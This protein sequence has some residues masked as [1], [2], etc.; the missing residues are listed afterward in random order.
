MLRICTA[1]LLCILLPGFA[2]A[3]KRVALVIGIDRYDNLDSRVQLKKARADAKGVAET[4]RS[5]GFDVIHKDDVARSAFNSHWQDFLNKLAAGDTAAFYFAGHGIELGGRNYLI[6]RDVPGVRPGRDEL[7]KRESLSLQEFLADLREKGTRLNLVILDACRDNPFDQ[8]AGRSVGSARGLAVTE[9]PEGTFIMYSAGTGESALD[10]LSDAD[11]NPNSVY[12]RL[13]LPLLKTKG[14][15]LTEVAEQ[16]RVNVRQITSTVQH[17]QTPAYY[18]QVIGRVCLAGGDCVSSAPSPS[19][20]KAVAIRPGPFTGETARGLFKATRF[21]ELDAWAK[22]HGLPLPDFEIEVP[23]ADVPANLRRFI[24]VWRAEPNAEKHYRANLLIV[25]RVY[26]DGRVDGHWAF[27]R[28]MP[29]ARWQYPAE[30]LPIAGRI[31]DQTLRFENSA[32]S[33]KYRFALNPDSTMD[34]MFSSTRG[35]L[36]AKKFVPFWTLLEAEKPLS[37]KAPAGKKAQGP[38]QAKPTR[39]APAAK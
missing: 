3:Q 31:T 26:K 27:G 17:R 5:L 8:V 36:A 21:K 14:I 10:S 18:N 15:S 19:S 23:G 4:L 39:P 12:T 30:T 22:R 7:L 24:G 28:P 35:E 37:A 29:N 13:L 34:Y 2:S 33:A 20:A 38:P 6:P 32:G 11:T 25:T 9:P 16:V 1:L